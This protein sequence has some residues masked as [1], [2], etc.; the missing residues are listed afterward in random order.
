VSA[1]EIVL[2]F[3][4]GFVIVWWPWELW[5]IW[6]LHWLVVGMLAPHGAWRM[7]VRLLGRRGREVP[8]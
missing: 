8:L 7:G 6:S 3:G 4:G 5:T 2:A 1:P